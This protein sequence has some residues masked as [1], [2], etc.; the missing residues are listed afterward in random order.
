VTGVREIEWVLRK[1]RGE[2]SRK[3]WIGRRMDGKGVLTLG[4][5]HLV[6]TYEVT[7]GKTA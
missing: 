3:E 7:P 5:R 4:R 6:N 1:E 2:K